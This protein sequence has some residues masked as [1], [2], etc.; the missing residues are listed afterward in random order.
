MLALHKMMYFRELQEECGLVGQD[1]KNIGLLEFE[2]EGTP[3]ILEVHVFET[4]KY[5]GNV[6]ESEG[7]ALIYSFAQY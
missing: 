6:T 5:H 1:L 7:K 3:T 2:F 4:H